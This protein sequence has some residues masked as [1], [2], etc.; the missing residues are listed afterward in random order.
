MIN[1]AV[2]KYYVSGDPILN[3]FII[4]TRYRIVVFHLI[5]YNKYI[6]KTLFLLQS[7]S[8]GNIKDLKPVQGG[9]VYGESELTFHE[10][11]DINGQKL[12]QSGGHKVINDDGKVIEYDFK[13]QIHH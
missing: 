6:T 7:L 12:E 13:P 2:S 5:L 3:L 8:L 10:S 9:H 11:S 1:T 4:T